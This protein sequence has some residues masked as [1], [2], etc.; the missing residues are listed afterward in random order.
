MSRYVPVKY[1]QKTL[2][3]QWIN[4]L[5]HLHDLHCGCNDPLEHTIIGITNQEKN[6]RFTDKEKQQLKKCLFGEENTTKEE[7]I[8]DEDLAALF[9][10]DYGDQNTEEDA[11]G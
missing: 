10:E 9:T 2:Q 5:V 11:T 6:L 7:E 4:G 3:L 1:N 8:G